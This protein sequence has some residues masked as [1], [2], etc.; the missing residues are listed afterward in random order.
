MPPPNLGLF[1][2]LSTEALFKFNGLGVAFRV[3]FEEDPFSELARPLVRSV[4]DE[5]RDEGILRLGMDGMPGSLK[6]ASC[7]ESLMA[8]RRLFTCSDTCSN[9][10]SSPREEALDR[11]RW[12]TRDSSDADLFRLRCVSCL[13]ID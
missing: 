3:L 6:F 2:A 10:L 11:V 5:D 4:R 13:F 1:F 12:R 8:F 9:R 7:H